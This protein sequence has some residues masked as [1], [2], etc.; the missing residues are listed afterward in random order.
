MTV[1]Y[2]TN[3]AL[4]QPVTGTESG[5]WGDDV[6][7]SVTSYLDIAIAGGL[8]VSITTTDVTLTLTQGTS[9]ATNIGS[10]TAQYAILNVSG[11]MTAARNLIL[12][13][14]SRQYVINNNTTGGFALTVKGSATS[15]VTMVNGEKAHVFW[16]GSD[17]AKLSNTPGGAGTFSSITNTGLTSGRVVYSTTG[18][19]ETDSANLTFDGT[20]LGLAGGTANGVAYL[21]GS[22]V[23]TTG[24]ALTWDTNI[25]TAKGSNGGYSLA[26]DTTSTPLIFKS[27]DLTGSSYAPI[28]FSLG[29]GSGSYTEQMRLT[30]T[31]L[32]IGTTSPTSALTVGAGGIARFNRADNATYNEI[33]YVTSGDLF[34]F[35]QANGGA[36]QFNISGTEQ[37]RLTSTGL[38]IGTSSPALK[39]HVVSSS[40]AVSYFETSD[41][42]T[43][44]YVIWRN[45]S[46]SIG[47]VGSGKGISGSGNATDFM[48]ASRSTYPLLFG[49]GSAERAR[50]DSSGNVGIGT[51]SPAVKL[52]V[53]VSGS[54]VL[55]LT[56][57][58]G[59]NSIYQTINNT[60]GSF[61]I[62]R[63]NSA[64]TTFGVSA[65]ASVLF[66][67]GAYPMIFAT[68]NIERMRIDSSGNV[69]IGT[70][71]PS[72]YGKLGLSV[73]ATASAVTKVIGFQNSAG[74]DAASLRIAG[75]NYADN[76][77]TAID[78]IQNSAS[79]FQSQM[80][81]STNTGSGLVEA[82]RIDSSGRVMI[83][84]TSTAA[85]FVVVG[86]SA[87]SYI[88]IDNSGSGENYFGANSANIFQTAGTERMRI[89][90]SG[91]LLVGTTSASNITK[92]TTYNAGNAFIAANTATSN[93]TTPAMQV[94]KGDNNTTTSNV[95]VQFLTNGFVNGQ[96]QIN[97]NGASAAA[98]GSFSDKRLKEN[99][100]DL[101]SQLEKIMALRP[102]EF[103][104]VESI[105]GGHQ[106]GFIAQEVET[107]YP[108]LVG[109]G[110]NEMLTL[111]DLNKNDA[112]LIKC[113]Q[114]Q[115]ALITS[116]TA[117][118]TALE[119]T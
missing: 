88:A 92:L 51:S 93:L 106:I 3:L 103:D 30:I 5:T 64:G 77:Q 72:S 95:L 11:A 16:N 57:T 37:M 69:G 96:G 56:A 52:D 78:F 104:Y 24:S 61:A 49:T 71:T 99:I 117:R 13:S 115:Q 4:G 76:V 15:G 70:T 27:N 59:T 10:T 108:D 23:L 44:A 73:S 21:N 6:N 38:G 112:R 19:L 113:I 98:F 84:T 102:V 62:G 25:F 17:Y 81:F 105:G 47:D 33:K 65:Y 1:N 41:T 26:F 119:S 32:G 110:E 109:V 91:N 116:L 74:V 68:Q 53:Q 94:S 82:M 58:T 97:A 75:Y 36:Y 40:A 28:A 85:K 90:S 55:K 39:L 83:G 54:E 29:N 107:V 80:A 67:A 7:N 35:N 8:S 22:K 12:P 60:G 50:I 87:N 66:S 20:N 48:I 9:S 14:S 101:P 2:T 63:E 118:I 46:T 114:E 45:S 18:G 31:G 100:V 34:Y 43:G 42:A 111:T 79:N 86:A 89:D